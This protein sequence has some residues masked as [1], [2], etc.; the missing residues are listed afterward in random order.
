MLKISND[1]LIAFH[2]GYYIKQYLDDQ[3][4]NQRELADR[5]NTNEKRVS[6][7]VNGKIELDSNLIESL[8]LVL[9]TSETL[10]KNLNDKYLETKAQIEKQNRLE[11]EKTIQKEID[12]KFWSDLGLVKPTNNT[13]EKIS[14]LKKFFHIST[15]KVLENKDFLVQYKTSIPEVKNKNVIN[16]NAW[17]QTALNI[18][19]SYTVEPMNL[20]YLKSMLPE[21]REMTT[22]NLEEVISRLKEIFKN[23]G[24]AF[25]ILPNLKNCGINGAVKWFGKDKVLL[26]MNDRRNDT[27]VFWFALF[28]E[29]EHVFQQKK[30]HIIISAED[31]IG[32]K[33]ILDSDALEKEADTFAQN[34]LIDPIQYDKF[35]SE[36]DFSSTAIK[37][38]A[39][40]IRIHPRIVAGRLQ[41]EKHLQLNTSKKQYNNIDISNSTDHT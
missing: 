24:V 6:E 19:Y 5:L 31:N 17:V 37:A 14:E 29:I 26:A 28:H 9:G 10:W 22:K 34:Y 3:S 27:D 38:F 12:Y 41:R 33:S 23:S 36:D 18:G 8:A 16:S 30:G 35:V 32:L 21:I 15:L 4:M 1:N 39:K 2:P 11:Q 7:L 25:V 20:K 40:E 13:L